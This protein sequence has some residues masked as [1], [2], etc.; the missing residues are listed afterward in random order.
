MTTVSGQVGEKGLEPPRFH[1]FSETLL[2]CPSTETGTFDEFP[3]WP[4]EMD[5]VS[6]LGSHQMAAIGGA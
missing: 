3:T 6:Q 5:Q 4:V 1:V 2:P